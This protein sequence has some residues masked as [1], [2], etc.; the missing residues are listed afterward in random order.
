MIPCSGG[1]N[2]GVTQTR[3][4]EEIE[5]EALELI[6][7]RLDVFCREEFG[8]RSQFYLCLGIMYIASQI[9]FEWL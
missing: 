1:D 6:L 2:V 7:A 4:E 5:L 3:R 9:L 8:W